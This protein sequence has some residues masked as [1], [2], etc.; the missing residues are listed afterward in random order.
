MH[1]QRSAAAGSYRDPEVPVAASLS[2]EAELRRRSLLHDQ[3]Y[4]AGLSAGW[5]AGVGIPHAAVVSADDWRCPVG[6]GHLLGL[7]WWIVR[8][9]IVSDQVCKGTWLG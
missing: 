5:R 6:K 7:L 1:R 3:Q 2:A 4:L 9:C 8:R